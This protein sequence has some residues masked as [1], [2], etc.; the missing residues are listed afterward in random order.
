[1]SINL[2]IYLE[3]QDADKTI[4]FARI[5]IP[6]HDILPRLLRVERILSRYSETVR[7]SPDTYRFLWVED[8]IQDNLEALFPGM[9]VL[10]ATPFRVLRDADIDYEHE[11]DQAGDE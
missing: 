1:M 10:E 3:H 6:T 8:I 11:Q 9:S 4:E 5:K 7:Q 2:A